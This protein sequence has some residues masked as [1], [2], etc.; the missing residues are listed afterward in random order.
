MTSTKS[1]TRGH[2][3]F[4]RY[5]KNP[6]AS[7]FKPGTRFALHS[8]TVRLYLNCQC[9]KFVL[10]RW[11]IYVKH[12]ERRFLQIENNGWEDF[13]VIIL[14]LLGPNSGSLGGRII[15]FRRLALNDGEKESWG[16]LFEKPLPAG[17]DTWWCLE[18]LRH[19]TSRVYRPRAS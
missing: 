4:E 15:H 18:A 2:T 6:V 13:I 1:G 8:S 7:P 16:S 17:C 11:S 12:G 19:E 10:V 5:Q 14:S 3:L 9:F